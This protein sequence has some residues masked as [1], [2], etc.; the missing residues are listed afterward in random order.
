MLEIMNSHASATFNWTSCHVRHQR[1]LLKI[2]CIRY[3]LLY[4]SLQSLFLHILYRY[5][6][7][8]T[9]R[10]DVW[11]LNS[12]WAPFCQLF[13]YLILLEKKNQSYAE[14]MSRVLGCIRTFYDSWCIIY[15][16]HALAHFLVQFKAEISIDMTLT[17]SE[18]LYIDE[19]GCWFV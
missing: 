1:R 16:P 19:K 8:I 3:T 18:Y 11:N 5:N 13:G 12:Y 6:E 7:K 14:R 2:Y 9:A 10:N 4:F 15:I 17:T